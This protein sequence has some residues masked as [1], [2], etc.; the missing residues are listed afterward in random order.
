M[1]PVL[2]DYFFNKRT[3]VFAR[4]EDRE[5]ALLYSIYNLPEYKMLLPAGFS[6]I[7]P[8]KVARQH[9]RFSF[10]CTGTFTIESGSHRETC[11]IIVLDCSMH[12]FL[13]HSTTPVATQV[14]GDAVIQLGRSEKSEI[15]ALAVGG[16]KDAGFYG[17]KLAEPDIVWRKFV[18]TLE[19]G[20]TH[21][22]MENAT[23]FLPD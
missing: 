14:W 12:G 7:D 3:E 20:T 4:L 21:D 16:K 23:R 8:G 6:D 19:S 5:K 2:L 15:R 22:D 10:K 1:T 18:A 11:E 9:Q 13:A 17:F